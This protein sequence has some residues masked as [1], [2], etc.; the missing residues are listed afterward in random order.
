MVRDYE[1]TATPFKFIASLVLLPLLVLSTGCGG[2]DSNNGSNPTN[3]PPAS[4]TVSSVSPAQ[5][6]TLG[7]T[8]VTITGTGFVVV[9][10]V[11]FGGSAAT[12]VVL[13]SATTLTAVTPAHAA[14]A[15]DVVVTNPSGGES[16]TVTGGF[17]YEAPPTP[18]TVTSV[19]PN[20][21]TVIGGET[22]TI[23]GTGF[24]G[25]PTVTFGGTAA[26][27]VVLTSSTSLTAVTPAHAAGAVNVVVTNP[28]GGASATLAN[29]FT[30][31]VPVTPITVTSVTPNPGTVLGGDTVTIT[32]TG[33]VAVPTVT[34]GGAT[35]T[36][37]VITSTTSLTVVTPAH[38]AGA[39]NVVVTNPGGASATLP[40]GFTYVALTVTS[41]TPNVGL[42]TGGEMITI[43][44]TGF[45]PN[46]TIS[47]GGWVATDVNVINN[48]TMTCRTTASSSAG[49]VNV[50]VTNFNG[51][52]VNVPNG[53][54]YVLPV[55]SISS[56]TPKMGSTFGGDTVTIAGAGFVNPT[57]TFGGIPA[58]MVS[59][60]TS[61]IKVV[62][63][64]RPNT[65][66]TD[67]VDV[68]V[69]NSG[70]TAV[71]LSNGFVFVAPFTLEKQNWIVDLTFLGGDFRIEADLDQDGNDLSGDYFYSSGGTNFQV[72]TEGLV[73]GDSIKVTFTLDKD[74]G[75][76]ASFECTGKL[77]SNSPQTFRGTFKALS[78]PGV[79]CGGVTP[80][81]GTFE[82]R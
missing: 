33:F 68:V 40:N 76:E 60:S 59:S 27:S 72:Y 28:S 79:I 82:F 41:I 54:T 66:V 11:T 25:V 64:P 5:G 39:V 81:E 65:S 71:T 58:S 56:V 48:M 46:V 1:R 45:R 29:G 32:G 67:T 38:A 62:T 69:T 15:V 47:F 44:G 14:G 23:T 13:T 78:N 70:G 63:A 35:A 22:V 16:T 50:R 52:Q 19:S 49:Q 73:F 8:T 53:F 24:L 26:T 21:G 74:T 6:T 43:T 20:K 34:F 36:S 10:T 2:G 42:T 12:N 9:P 75:N 31:E 7:G 30:Y 17:T 61:S 80:C 55:L 3:T 37:V 18:V 4:V 77:F 57:V 51:E